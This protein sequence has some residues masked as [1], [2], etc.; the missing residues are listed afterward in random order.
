MK[1]FSIINKLAIFISLA[2]TGASS[3]AQSRNLIVTG[4]NAFP[5]AAPSEISVSWIMPANTAEYKINSVEIYRNTRPITDI[6]D[7]ENARLMAKLP[8]GTVSYSDKVTTSQEY[9]YAVISLV[10]QNNSEAQEENLYYD[11]ELDSV[12]D[13]EA[14][15]RVS[16]VLPGVN[17][18]VFG[19]K[20]EIKKRAAK[21]IP[22]KKE[23]PKKTYENKMR[24]QPLPFVDILGDSDS[25]QST[26][27]DKAKTQVKDLLKAKR[28]SRE[29]S[30]LDYHVF[31]EDLVEPSG[32]DDYLLFDILKTT[33]IKKKYGECSEKLVKFLGQNRSKNVTNRAIFY[34][35]ECY[36]Y[37]G[38]FSKALGQFLL[39]EDVYPALS[40]KWS[41]STLDLYSYR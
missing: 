1:R 14:T 29:L 19:A 2:V 5:S 32:G 24:E 20:A 11:E 28:N 22:E 21:V 34:L 9:Y 38:D 27:S 41:E 10:S 7:L 12:K 3:F 36:Y 13:E 30:V 35:G 40:R 39:L 16:L 17:A 26:I 4:I 18:T 25:R 8:R 23:E 31:E 33:F 6:K 15:K 37:T